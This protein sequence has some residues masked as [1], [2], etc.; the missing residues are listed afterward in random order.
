ME[1]RRV[2]FRSLTELELS[3]QALVRALI[4]FNVGVELGQIA[5]VIVFLPLL[6]WAAR[7][8]RL[9][10]LPQALSVLVAAIGA[11]W[12]VERLIDFG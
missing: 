12:L 11:V 7:P 10:R 1:F 2:L 8:G 3:R 4:G 6:S 5:F 9:P